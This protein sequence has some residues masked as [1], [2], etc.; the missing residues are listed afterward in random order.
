MLILLLLV[1]LF[2]GS[3]ID[4]SRYVQGPNEGSWLVYVIGFDENVVQLN[5][6]QFDGRT[7]AITGTLAT[8][9]HTEYI[10]KNATLPIG[11]R[12]RLQ[13]Y[14]YAWKLKLADE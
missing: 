12:L 13:G 6:V 4:V 5:D 2:I 10:Q 9:L 1:V 11:T 8:E 3:K 14:G 7:G